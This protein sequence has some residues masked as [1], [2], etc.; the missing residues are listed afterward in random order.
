MKDGVAHRTFGDQRE[1]HRRSFH[2]LV[3]AFLEETLATK[4]QDRCFR[5]QMTRMY[6]GVVTVLF[7]QTAQRPGVPY[8]EK[9]RTKRYQLA[10]L[11]FAKSGLQTYSGHC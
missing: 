9:H 1:L 4:R 3:V 7:G 2:G 5:D 8:T 6:R 10:R 11:P